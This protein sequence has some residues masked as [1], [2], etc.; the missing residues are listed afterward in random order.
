M[1]HYSFAWY[2]WMSSHQVHCAADP[3]FADSLAL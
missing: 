1:V 3:K 2:S